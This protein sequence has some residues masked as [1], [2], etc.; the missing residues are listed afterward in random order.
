MPNGKYI[1]WD[2]EMSKNGKLIW[3]LQEKMI[4]LQTPLR[5]DIPEAVSEW[6]VILEH[7]GF[8]LLSSEPL[9]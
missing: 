6:T 9:L 5:R 2:H 3:R 8:S 1:F 4:I 7:A